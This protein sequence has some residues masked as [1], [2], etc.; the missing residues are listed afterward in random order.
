MSC[1]RLYRNYLEDYFSGFFWCTRRNRRYYCVV[2]FGVI[3][4]GAQWIHGDEGNPL[5]HEMNKL[6]LL[7]Y[8][9][10]NIDD[11]EYYSEFAV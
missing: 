8:R 2:G 4:Y 3:E 7:D 10:E 5:Y 11:E 9:G 1:I 6:G